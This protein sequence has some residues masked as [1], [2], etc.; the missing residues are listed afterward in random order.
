MIKNVVIFVLVIC[1]LVL[2]NV[3]IRLENYHYASVVGMCK[4]YNPNDPMQ[5]V[6]RQKCLNNTETRTTPL[7]HIFFAITDQ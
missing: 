4:E 7:A 2:S 6:K 5:T 3:V 1:V